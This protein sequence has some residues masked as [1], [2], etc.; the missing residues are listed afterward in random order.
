MKS[1][2]HYPVIDDETKKIWNIDILQQHINNVHKLTNMG[3]SPNDHELFKSNYVA[4]KKMIRWNN[5]ST[6][7]I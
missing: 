4:T 1:M 7:Q 6:T 5:F 3:F 2:K